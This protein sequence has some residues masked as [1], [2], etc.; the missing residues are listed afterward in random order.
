MVDIRGEVVDPLGSGVG[1][2]SHVV[3]KVVQS[4]RS[5][6]GLSTEICKK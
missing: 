2:Y 6:Y 5:E 1:S 4:R 3:R